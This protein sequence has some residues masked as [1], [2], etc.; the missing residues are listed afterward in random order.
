VQ[1][2]YFA[3]WVRDDD[4]L[5]YPYD[6]ERNGVLSLPAGDWVYTIGIDLGVVDAC[7][8]VV[9]AYRRGLP[10]RY[11]V[12]AEKHVG[13]IPSR[14]AI[15]V[16][17]LLQRFPH[18]RVVADAGGLGKAYVAEWQETYGLPVEAADKVGV[19]G[20]IG[21]CAGWLKTGEAKL[22]VGECRPL[23]EELAELWWSA[24]RKGHDSA[25]E[26]HCADAMRY[27]LMAMT[28]VYRPQE[29]EPPAGSREALAKENAA[30]KAKAMAKG[31]RKHRAANDN[32]ELWEVAA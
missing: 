2:E 30:R 3:R 13:M 18:A 14:A 22:L 9:G 24:D 29:E 8:F 23:L 11:I 17:E 12:H 5:C 26:D 32:W 28:P 20:Q 7:A 6:H 19:A 16:E 15:K 31:M 25:C 4:A 1:R 21:L 27:C 10:D